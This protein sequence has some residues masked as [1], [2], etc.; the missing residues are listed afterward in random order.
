MNQLHLSACIAEAA[1]L[2]YTPAGL[3]ALDLVL[4]HEST[5][6]ASEGARQVRVSLR[7]QALAGMAERLATQAIG[8][9]WRFSGFLS[10]PRRGRSV[11]LNIQDFQ[12]D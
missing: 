11:V 1:P 2:R 9:Q 8:S 7:A 3:P 10:T 6:Q 4:E 5:V 12:Q